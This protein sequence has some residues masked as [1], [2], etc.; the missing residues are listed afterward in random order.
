VGV[1]EYDDRVLYEKLMLDGFQAGL[2]HDPA[3]A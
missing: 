1:P 2:D 3:Q